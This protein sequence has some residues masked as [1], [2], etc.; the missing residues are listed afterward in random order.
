MRTITNTFIPLQEIQTSLQWMPQT[1]HVINYFQIDQLG[2]TGGVNGGDCARRITKKIISKHVA[3][4]MNF[5]GNGAK[6][7]LNHTTVLEV[8]KGAPYFMF[9]EI[10][11][12]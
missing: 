4:R 6:M 11:S 2:V 10:F 7:G 1:V 9:I 3:G 8:I 5:C 12:C